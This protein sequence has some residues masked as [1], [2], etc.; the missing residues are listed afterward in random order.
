MVEV[1]GM[2]LLVVSGTKEEVVGISMVVEGG[3]D[4][5]MMLEVVMVD[6]VVEVEGSRVLVTVENEVVRLTV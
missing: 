4:V 1:M 3:M 6:S 5:V 2:T